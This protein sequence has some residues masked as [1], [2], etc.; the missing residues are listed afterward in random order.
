MITTQTVNPIV[1]H[2]HTFIFLVFI[3]PLIARWNYSVDLIIHVIKFEQCQ[4]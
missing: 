1:D 2:T 4:A 3:T